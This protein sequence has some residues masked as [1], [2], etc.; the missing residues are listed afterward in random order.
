MP[1]DVDVPSGASLDEAIENLKQ[2]RAELRKTIA[3]VPEN[4]LEDPLYDERPVVALA[5]ST[6]RHDAWHASQIAVAK[7]L[8]RMRERH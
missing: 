4:E 3:N 5:R 7:R 6:V 8:Y 1:A 2:L